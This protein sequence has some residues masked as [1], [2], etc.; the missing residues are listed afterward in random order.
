MANCSTFHFRYGDM[1]PSTLIGKL[2]GSICSLS[3][4]VVIA[5]P[6]PVIVTSFSRIYTRN[7]RIERIR[8][9]SMLV[10]DSTVILGFIP[11]SLKYWYTGGR[12]LKGSIIIISHLGGTK[13]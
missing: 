1:V 5:L 6:V 4:V 3:G 13:I 7:Q 2:V 10:R 11:C 8:D 12:K 9:R